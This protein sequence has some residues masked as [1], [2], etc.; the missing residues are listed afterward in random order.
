MV[1]CDI[2]PSGDTDDLHINKLTM[3]LDLQ[4]HLCFNC[5]KHRAT[6][7]ICHMVDGKKEILNLCSACVKEFKSTCGVKLQDF[8]GSICVYCGRVATSGHMNQAWERGDRQGTWN[9]TCTECCENYNQ[10]LTKYLHEFAPVGSTS[11]Q[12]HQLAEIFKK[13]DEEVRVLA[14]RGTR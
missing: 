10:M 3:S 8:H 12:T 5:K 7:F 2:F 6:H 1:F 14:R 4:E 9:F 13:V 11:E